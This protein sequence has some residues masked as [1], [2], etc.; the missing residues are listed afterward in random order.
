[1]GESAGPFV[2]GPEEERLPAPI[3]GLSGGFLFAEIPVSIRGVT[4]VF[5]KRIAKRLSWK[6]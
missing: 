1:M 3:R 4:I 2:C 5:A 6:L